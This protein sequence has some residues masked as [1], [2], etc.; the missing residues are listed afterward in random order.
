VLPSTQLI[1]LN[2]APQKYKGAFRGPFVLQ[3]FAAS[4]IAFQGAR[5]IDGLDDPDKSVPRSYGGL[6]LAA[7]AVSVIAT[8]KHGLI[9]NF[10]GS[11]SSVG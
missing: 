4:L 9:L 11:R 8:M 5:K 7:A 10:F 2:H 6:A 3:T 1:K